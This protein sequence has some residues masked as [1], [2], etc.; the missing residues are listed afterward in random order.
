MLAHTLAQPWPNPGPS[1]AHPWP[2]PGL[3]LAYP[4]PILWLNLT[5]PW[6]NLAHP[7]AQPCLNLAPGLKFKNI[8]RYLYAVRQQM[9]QSGI[10]DKVFPSR[11]DAKVRAM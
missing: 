3:S 5:H 7:L 9:Q 10:L 11:P 2:I 6:S 1:L 4:W 8:I